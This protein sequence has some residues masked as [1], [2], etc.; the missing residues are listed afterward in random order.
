MIYKNKITEEMRWLGEK[1]NAVFIGYNLRCGS[2]GYGTMIGVPEDKIYEM[3]VNESLM[4]G[5]AI[6]MALKGFLPVVVF[7][8]HDFL[9]QGLCQI[10]NHLDKIEDMSKGEF[11][12]QVIIRA[13]VGADTPLNPGCQHTQ[14]YTGALKRMNLSIAVREY[15]KGIYKYIEDCGRS[16]IVVEYRDLYEC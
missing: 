15:S 12:P 14:D 8:R 10:V 3:P 16:A 6:G 4:V 11:T 2:K 1:E 9:L 5:V 7:E 13:I